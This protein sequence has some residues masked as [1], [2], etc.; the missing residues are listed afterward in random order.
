MMADKRARIAVC[1]AG[2]FIGGHLI[3]DLRRQGYTKLRAVDVKPFDRWYQQFPDV[4]NVSLDLQHLDSCRNAVRDAAIVFNLA[5]DMGGMGFIESNKA[6]CMLSVLINTHLL[7]AS[8]EAGVERF[9]FSSSACVYSHD[10]QTDPILAGL[11]EEEAY[12]ERP[13]DGS[14]WDMSAA[15]TRRMRI[16]R[17]PRTATAGRSSSA[18]GCAGTSQRTSV[19]SRASRGIT[20]CTGLTAPTTAAGRRRRPR[21]HGRSR[22]RFCRAATTSRSGAAASRP[23]ASPTSTIASSA[24]KRSW[25]A[26]PSRSRSTWEAARRSP[27]ISSSTSLKRSL[28]SD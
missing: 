6:L 1:G 14:G 15:C 3:A 16:A 4:E 7:M 8:R 11:A 20:T 28:E 12:P 23:G 18:N 24:R 5:A 13:Q 2:G 10:K 27:S 17:C 19:W 26:T 22:R 25:R 9:F 21:S